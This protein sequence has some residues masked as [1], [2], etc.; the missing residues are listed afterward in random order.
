MTLP[1]NNLDFMS[2]LKTILRQG[3]AFLPNVLAGIFTKGHRA[4]PIIYKSVDVTLYRVLAENIRK[5]QPGQSLSAQQE[6]LRMTQL[7]AVLKGINF[8]RKLFTKGIGVDTIVDLFAQ[9]RPVFFGGEVKSLSLEDC[10]R[11]E[12]GF[13]QFVPFFFGI[14]VSLGQNLT[15][16]GLAQVKKARSEPWQNPGSGM[17]SFR[18]PGELRAMP[19]LDAALKSHSYA[20]DT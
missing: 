6:A 4:L 17:E 16:H 19:I 8:P 1:G 2:I 7:E 3:D 15:G 9:T 13:I 12:P 14:L 20:G 11:S 18:A 10:F 5:A